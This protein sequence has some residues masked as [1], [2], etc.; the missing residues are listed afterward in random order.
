M[1]NQ[2]QTFI[3]GK[4]MIIILVIAL[5]I[6]L[7]WTVYNWGDNGDGE[8]W[9]RDDGSVK[10]SDGEGHF[11]ARPVLEDINKYRITTD[12]GIAL[13]ITEVTEEKLVRI[14][15]KSYTATHMNSFQ[16]NTY[17]LNHIAP[18]KMF[19]D[20]GVVDNIHFYYCIYTSPN[21]ARLF[22]FIGGNGST[23]K[24]FV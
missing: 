7:V 19:R 1:K 9:F 6:A 23:T 4:P 14:A 16:G 18:I 2:E 5:F 15:R 13:E 20:I 8:W 11:E 22:L 12:A 3:S 17:Q 21:G 10:V 24:Y